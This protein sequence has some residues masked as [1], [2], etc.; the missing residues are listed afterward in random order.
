MIHFGSLTIAP[1]QLVSYLKRSVR[2]RDICKQETY[3]RIVMATAQEKGITVDEEEIQTEANQLRHQMK[4]E[5]AKE[6]LRWLDE[7]LITPADWEDGIRER[8]LRQKLAKYLFEPQVSAYFTQHKLS[9][10]KAIL[11]RIVVR[12]APLAQE[13]F[14]Q[15]AEAETSF[16]QAAHQYDISEQR[17]FYCG[18]EGQLSRQ[19]LKPDV[20]AQVFGSKPKD[21]LGPIKSEQG[22]DLL[23]VEDFLAAELTDE[24]RT[25]IMNQLLNEWLEREVVYLIHQ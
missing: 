3:G 9:Y 8:L 17:R 23:M 11:Y 19:N 2:I 18:Y 15:I 14:Y 16:Y 1:Q 25:Q 21:I 13:L 6:T 22:Y 4:L 24:L 7:Q 20:A 5:S 10:D 12:D